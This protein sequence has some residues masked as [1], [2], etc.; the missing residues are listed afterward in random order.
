M[1][2]LQRIGVLVVDDERSIGRFVD[3][4]LRSLGFE[5]IV[6]ESGAEALEQS[7]AMPQIDL[8]L[9]DMMM[10]EMS[11]DEV[12][13]R[14]RAQHPDLKVLYLTGHSDQLFAEKTVL[15]EEIGRAH[16]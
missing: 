4:A 8:L 6:T 7:A 13:R 11:G 1:N 15:W 9:T 14:L 3:R 5:P 2:D 16:V 12:A 10:P